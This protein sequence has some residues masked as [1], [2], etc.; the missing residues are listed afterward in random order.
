MYIDD[1]R[2]GNIFRILV[3]SLTVLSFWVMHT[4]Q[5]TATIVHNVKIL[6]SQLYRGFLNAIVVKTHSSKALL[7]L[8]ILK[9]TVIYP[10]ILRTGTKV[11]QAGFWTILL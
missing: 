2:G 1:V 9:T 11:C 10:G 6:N 5:T 4:S 8:W 3:W 7:K